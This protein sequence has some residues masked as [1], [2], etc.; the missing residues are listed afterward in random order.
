MEPRELEKAMKQ[1]ALTRREAL[2]LLALSPAAVLGA[3]TA[4]GCASTPPEP[5]RKKLAATRIVIVG[6][7]S[8]GITVATRLCNALDQPD[9]T[10]IEPADVHYYQPGFTLIGS[11]V[12]DADD[13]T[14][15]EADYM[16][17]K[18]KWLKEKVTEVH[19]D[20]NYLVTDGGKKVEYDMLVL[21]PGMQYRWEKI[22]GLKEGVGK[23]GLH[24]IYTHEGAVKTWEAVQKFQG[25]TALFTKPEGAI[26][27]GGAPLKI[28]WMT[29][30][31]LRIWGRREKAEI[32]YM[33]S[34]PQLFG[35][36]RYNPELTRITKERNIAINTGHTLLAVDGDKK[37]ALFKKEYEI[38]T[39]DDIIFKEEEVTLPYDLLHTPP[40]QGAPDFVE[41][42]PLAI[43]DGDGKGYIEVDKFTLQHKR[44]PNIFALGD[45][46]GIPMGKTG[47][48]VRKQAPVL[49]ENLISVASGG[50]ASA[51][52]DGYT[53]CPLVTRHGRVVLAE[54][55]Y[56]LKPRGTVP[57][58]DN[59]KEQYLFW[60][61]KVYILQPMYWYGMLRGRA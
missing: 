26:K 37:E 14:R 58:I 53:V 20:E 33:T 28:M 30:D 8:G 41:Q 60:V 56:S 18:A 17:S 44:Y 43:A 36:D 54:F 39:E 10:V 51:K 32:A 31:N 13:V 22:P 4:T 59:T 45:A 55:D 40:P 49:V 46:A 47:G 11:G 5:V 15:K 23:N 35:I 7:G 48:S 52:Y 24:S 42:S 2:K 25:G 57:L 38:E 50:K 34:G 12:Y 19:P 3:G 1:G 29:D 21:S 9:V 27:C 6:G 61:M 16:P